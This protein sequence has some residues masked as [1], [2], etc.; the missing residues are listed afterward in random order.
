MAAPPLETP[1]GRDSVPQV[2]K[3][4]VKAVARV[5]DFFLRGVADTV[6]VRGNMQKQQE[7]SLVKY[8]Y[9]MAFLAEHGPNMLSPPPV[10]PERS[11]R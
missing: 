6:K 9:A 4:R 2:E 1:A 10:T 3:L 5:R 7:H 8:A 11:I